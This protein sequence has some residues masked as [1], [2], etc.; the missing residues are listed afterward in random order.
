MTAQGRAPYLLPVG[1]ARRTLVGRAAFGTLLAAAAFFVFTATKQIRPVYFRAPWEND[2]YD[3]VFSFTMFFVPLIAACLLVQVSLCRKSEPLP[4]SRVVAILR[5]CRVAV[6]AIVIEL[7][8]AWAAVAFGANRSEWTGRATGTLIALLI[9]CTAA[10]GKVI[11]DLHHAPRLRN[12][13]R[14]ESGQAT[15]LLADMVTVAERESRWLGPLCRPGLSVLHWADLHLVSAVRRHPLLAAAAVSGVFAVAVFG[16]QAI[17]EQY[18]LAVTLLEMGLGF[19]GMFAFLVSAGS[20]LG[21]ARSPN[22][23]YGVQRRAVDASVAGCVVTICVL[24]FRDSLWWIVGSS[25]SAAGPG[26]F[27][28]LAGSMSLLAFLVVF[29]AETLL[30]WHSRPLPEPG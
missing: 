5:G 10:T 27:A 14:A 13:G 2:P 15:D 12:P 16:W 29:A 1:D 24:A 9:L 26:Q 19:C 8:T 23:L 22:I 3:T 28:M 21:V 11:V 17:R 6:G 18:L 7:V 20:Y 30:R 25:P 4:A